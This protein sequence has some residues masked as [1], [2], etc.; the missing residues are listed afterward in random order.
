MCFRLP[1]LRM[2]NNILLVLLILSILGLAGTGYTKYTGRRIDVTFYEEKAMQYAKPAVEKIKSS[3]KHI[4][5]TLQPYLNTARSQISD[6]LHHAETFTT[7]FIS[8]LK[9]QYFQE[10]TKAKAKQEL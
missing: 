7:D 4:N 9:S 1:G 2:A 5:T 6:V 3:Y 10:P 8:S